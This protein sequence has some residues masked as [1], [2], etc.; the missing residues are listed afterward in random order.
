MKKPIDLNP[1]AFRT[2]PPPREFLAKIIADSFD[3]MLADPALT[4]KDRTIIH[5]YKF[6]FESC[7]LPIVDQF[8]LN[9][10]DDKIDSLFDESDD[11]TDNTEDTEVLPDESDGDT[12][13]E[14]WLFVAFLDDHRD[15]LAVRAERLARLHGL[16]H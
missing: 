9:F 10:T 3:R 12:D 6:Q 14:A 16:P 8:Q 1:P 7:I 5:D 4:P 13:D 15:E 2:A 11:N